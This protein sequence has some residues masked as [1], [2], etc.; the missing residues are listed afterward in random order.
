MRPA[1]ERLF[2]S[3]GGALDLSAKMGSGGEA[4]FQLTRV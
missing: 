2:A 4:Y 3:S 1:A